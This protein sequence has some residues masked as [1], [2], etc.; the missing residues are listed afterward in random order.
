MKRNPYRSMKGLAVVMMLVAGS[1]LASGCSYL[2]IV[3]AKTVEN[4]PEQF[5]KTVRVD[6]IAKQQI[7]DP[8]E[9]TA[10]VTSSLQMKVTA[11]QGGE[12]AQILK[13]RG[14]YVK[15]GDTILRLASEELESARTKAELDL[16]NAK[17]NLVRAKTEGA[18]SAAQMQRAID[19][20]RRNFNKLRN[21][22]DDGTVTETELETAQTELKNAE[23]DLNL[24]RQQQRGT[25]AAAETDVYNA[26]SAL[27][28]ADRALAELE[29]KAPLSGM[30]TAMPLEIGM[31]LPA[32]GE[33]GLIEVLNPVNIKANLS[34]DAAKYVRGKQE[35]TYYTADAEQKSKASI[36]FLANVINP[37]TKA[38]DLI[39]EV[40]NPDTALKPGT[41]VRVQLTDENEQTAVA[42]PTQ[43]ILKEGEESFVFVLNGDT[44]EK[45]RV[46]LGRLNEPLQEVL[47]GVK[48]NEWLV[49]SG[50]RQLTNKEKVRVLGQSTNN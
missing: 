32:G 23:S 46:E 40:P 1:V 44:V 20:Q 43:S 34:A 3:G 8:V 30:L 42:I 27:Q 16:K 49:I 29:V 48:E 22:Y 11:K 35:L 24:F 28:E 19:Q 50:Q 26:Q 15:T 36:K 13:K 10:E 37:D 7:G 14:D 4:N 9:A 31:N 17:D 25:T 5:L 41:P 18:A 2:G 21:D 45:R 39:L 12:V 33:A 38:Y 47:S 6:K